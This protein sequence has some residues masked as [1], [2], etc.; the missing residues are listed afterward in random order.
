M[1][2]QI[3]EIEHKKNKIEVLLLHELLNI[4]CGNQIFFLLSRSL[5][6]TVN[7][8]KNMI[9]LLFILCKRW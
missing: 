6:Q 8:I 9:V 7:I 3:M 2:L 4:F 5:E 1:K